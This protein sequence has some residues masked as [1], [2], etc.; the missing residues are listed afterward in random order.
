VSVPLLLLAKGFTAVALPPVALPPSPPLLERTVAPG[1]V[2]LE[3]D[4]RVPRAARVEAPVA[5]DM[6]GERI[7]VTPDTVLEAVTLD[8]PPAEALGPVRAAY[9]V[10]PKVDIAKVSAK[11]VASAVAFGLFGGMMRTGMDPRMCLLDRDAD[12]RFDTAVHL[13]A[14]RKADLRP[15]TMAPTPYRLE[16]NI[17]PAAD[18]ADRVRVL[19][20][21]PKGSSDR[22]LLR[23]QVHI[24]DD[25][26]N[27]SWL[28]RGVEARSLPATVSIVGGARLTIAAI[29]P[30][31]GEARVR[32]DQP[33][34]TPPPLADPNVRVPIYVYGPSYR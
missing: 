7:D 2:M 5:L 18:V 25:W 8:G 32:I 4:V 26:K 21:G 16:T 15:V 34:D 27:A 11:A 23:V 13:G 3:Q 10:R 19:Y 24:G 17:A 30:T 1:D 33:F 28:K 20:E 31:S 14:K 12:G 9:C 22:G 29:D 6:A